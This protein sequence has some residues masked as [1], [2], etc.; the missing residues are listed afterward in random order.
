MVVNCL[1]VCSE[2]LILFR[3]PQDSIFIEAEDWPQ[4]LLTT[5]ACKIQSHFPADGGVGV[6][7]FLSL[8]LPEACETGLTV[9]VSHALTFFFL[10]S[11]LH[12]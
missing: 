5:M 2:N 7:T 3:W 1:I 9:F 8:Y 11:S 12:Y 10:S 6:A 4:H